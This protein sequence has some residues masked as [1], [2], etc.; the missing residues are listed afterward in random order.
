MTQK[1]TVPTDVGEGTKIDI[2]SQDWDY[3]VVLDACRYDYF[4]RL[5]EGY[6]NGKL[7]KSISPG[8]STGEWVDKVFQ[9]RHDDV[10]YV[11]ANPHINS[12]VPVGGFDAKKHFHKVIDAW[13]TGWD[14]KLGTV[15]PGEVNKVV[16]KAVHEYPDKRIIVHYM[17]PH[18]PYLSLGRL[19]GA[20][21]FGFGLYAT[22]SKMD[23]IKRVIGETIER[24][25]G[26]G[27]VWELK[28]LL[29]IAP[30]LNPMEAAYRKV[31]RNGL[32]Q[33]YGENLKA[34][35]DHAS[36]LC[37]ELP[38]DKKI[39]ITAD[40]GELLGENGLYRHPRGK[41]V[42]LLVNVPWF[43]VER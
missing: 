29:K 3:L 19:K 15:P 11:S 17:Q 13:I 9:D 18:A 16:L 20:K 39:V 32:I 26:L 7:R 33:A 8:S 25:I 21:G 4:E 34:V 42:P 30:S 24:F 43:E 37:R 28:K 12:K 22:I 41:H 40:H 10:V 6:L 36:K 14:E 5:Y 1:E 27:G 2:M 31:G 35:L 38:K 23:R